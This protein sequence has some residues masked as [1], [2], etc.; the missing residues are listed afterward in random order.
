[1][2]VIA[3]R[4]SSNLSCQMRDFSGFSLVERSDEIIVTQ[5]QVREL[6]EIVQP[7]LEAKF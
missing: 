1:M 3:I 7:L 5:F 4:V 6:R 2:I